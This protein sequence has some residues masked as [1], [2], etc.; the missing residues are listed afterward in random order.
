MLAIK[1][2]QHTVSA[3]APATCGNAVVGFDIL[4]CALEGLGDTVSLQLRDDDQLIIEEITGQLSALTL[5]KDA[6][7]NVA[8]Y[9]L[10]RLLSDYDCRQGFTIRIHKGIPLGSGLGGSAASAVAAL[11]AFNA[12][13]EVPLPMTILR[14]YALLGEALAVDIPHGDNV[15]PALEG[16]LVL[17]Q[18]LDP[19]A[20]VSLPVPDLNW[21]LVCPN[22]VVETQLARQCVERSWELPV[23]T[24]QMQALAS[25]V[26]GLYENDV[27]VFKSN[28]RD[29]LILPHR[30]HLVPG[31]NAVYQSAMEAGAMT[32]A[33][34]GAG[35]TVL[36]IVEPD[37][38]AIRVQQEM[39]KA[40]G[41]AG[42]E[43]QSWVS[44]ISPQ[45][46]HLVE[47]AI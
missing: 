40:F 21:V 19:I 2:N 14:Q 11:V 47:G 28:M 26:A 15:F 39:V 18:S 33:L 7:S 13:L 45:G 32:C 20:L 42:I 6:Q 10:F 37:Q 27:S 3:F 44:A 22:V 46:A 5:P 17:I 23:I 4:G 1:K 9:V 16:G 36:A 25:F 43:S 31:F 30:L 38:D 8:S 24:Y 29:H 35:P 34:S 12:F 41:R